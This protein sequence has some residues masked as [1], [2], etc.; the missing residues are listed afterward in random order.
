MTTHG[1]ERER[2]F[3]L[4]HDDPRELDQVT[5]GVDGVTVLEGS[6]VTLTATYWDTADRRLL[7]WGHTLRHRSASD[8]SEDRWTLKLAVASRG[9][10][11][12]LEREEVHADAPPTFPPRELRSLVA[13]VIRSAPLEAIATLTTV[14]AEEVIERGADHR[15]AVEV[16]DDRVSSVVDRRPGSSFRQIEVEARGPD[17]APLMDAMSDVLSAAGATPTAGSKLERVV[18]DRAD[19]EVAVPP[20]GPSATIEAVVRAA[21]SSGAERLLRNDPAGR[22][23]EDPEAIHQMRV[24]TRRLRSDLRTLEPLLDEDRVDRLRGELGWIGGLLGAVRDLDVVIGRVGGRAPE[25]PPDRAELLPPIVDELRDER[26]RRHLE[27][28]NALGTPRYSRLVDDLVHAGASPPIASGRDARRRARNRLRKL[29][30]RSVRRVDRAVKRLP[31][32]PS[33]ADLHEIRKRAKRARYAA[34]LATGAFGKDARRLASRMEALQDELG[35]LQDAVMVQ[36][37]LATLGRHRLPSAPAFLAGVLTAGEL[38]RRDDVRATWR[39]SWKR[40]RARR[41]RRWLR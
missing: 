9:T 21:I 32:E 5:A 13:G 27:L 10:G 6:T 29:V 31:A 2:K 7:R 40:S 1:T 22:I 33:D 39:R 38:G 19:P 41:V 25:L 15:T 12:E 20:T 4:D 34:E 14:R 11:D 37:R 23:G 30:A 3:D 18:A 24:A 16:A 8:G 26:R 28:V 17:A 35:E 36:S